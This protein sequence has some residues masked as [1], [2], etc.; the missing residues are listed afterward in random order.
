MPPTGCAPA[1]C[2]RRA[3]ASDDLDLLSIDQPWAGFFAIEEWRFRHR[4]F[5]GDMGQPI[6]REVFV[7]PDAVTV[8]PY[9]PARDRVLLVEQFR[10]GPAARG[11][12][13]SWQIEAVAGMIDPGETPE[14]TARRETLEEAGLALGALHRVAGYYP[15]PGAHTEYVTSY[16]GIADLPDGVAGLGG[17]P[18]EHE[19]I[20][21]HL[22][23][24]EALMA[25]IE[26]GEAASGPLIV[27]ALWLAQAR[28]R[29]RAAATR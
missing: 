12:P 11:D 17:L 4:R 5:D 21:S 29:L 22:M 16:I 19:D 25:L 3:Q 6:L 15:S 2:L 23:S 9:D 13:Q 8:L 10:P 28:P 18:Q 20:R 24:F 7:T 26:S 14:E 1:P 27:S